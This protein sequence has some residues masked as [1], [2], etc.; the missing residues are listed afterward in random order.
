MDVMATE[1]ASRAVQAWAT[2]LG[3]P[4]EALLRMGL[5]AVAGGLVGLERELRETGGVSDESAGVPGQR[6]GHAGVG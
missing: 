6:A 5:A 1:T 3:W 4:G 2:G